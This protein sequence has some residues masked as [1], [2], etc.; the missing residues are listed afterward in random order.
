MLISH[1]YR[2]I[3]VHIQRTGGTSVSN[4][5]IDNDP[6]LVMK[7]PAENVSKRLIHCFISDLKPVLSADEFENYTKFSIVRNPYE[8]LYSWYLMFK[9]NSI[10]GFES[11][12]TDE[13][14]EKAVLMYDSIREK[15]DPYI[16]SFDDFLTVPNE[17]FFQRF[18][19]NQLDYLEINQ[20]FAMDKVLRFEHLSDDFNAFAKELN[21]NASLAHIN[22]SVSEKSYR[23]VY[24]EKA[25]KLV[26]ERFAKD[27]DFFGY[28]F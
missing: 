26:A 13:V 1:K 7:L 20:Q 24:S 27:L 14:V 21:L 25:K 10:H 8:R 2:V 9:H 12:K 28:S 23:D 4:I 3:F 6:D 5:F 16:A 17:G 11:E 22:K 18:Y 15:L 19:Y